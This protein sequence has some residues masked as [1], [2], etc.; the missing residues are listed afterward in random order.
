M[1]IRF[2]GKAPGETLVGMRQVTDMLPIA[3]GKAAQL[4]QGMAFLPR[5]P[6]SGT[7]TWR[8]VTLS[9]YRG[10]GALQK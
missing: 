9:C 2:S 7:Q 6:G 8:K 3:S 10:F 4:G 1:G 5:A